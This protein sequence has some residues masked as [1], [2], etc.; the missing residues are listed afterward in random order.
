MN[1]RIYLEQ[2]TERVEE[3]RN[4]I[5]VVTGP[6]QVGKSPMYLQLLENT[7]IRYTY[8]SADGVMKSN[9]E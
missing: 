2:L 9:S 6:R 1:H 5:Q 3:Q 4:F 7:A 8:E